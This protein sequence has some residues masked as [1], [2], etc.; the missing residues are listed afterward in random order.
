M[1]RI[2]A[3]DLETSG[4][5]FTSVYRVSSAEQTQHLGSLITPIFQKLGTEGRSWRVGISG[6]QGAGKSELARG[7]VHPELTLEA[8]NNTCRSI[9]SI[10]HVQDSGNILHYDARTLAALPFGRLSD[11][12][13][14]AFY[15]GLAEH[16]QM[17]PR[18]NIEITEWPEDD[19]AKM[20]D[21]LSKIERLPDMDEDS[22]LITVS[23]SQ[24]L[25]ETA[26]FADFI[27]EADI[28]AC[29]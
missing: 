17:K 6:E 3:K 25:S 22:R 16:H 12:S 9:R 15:R 26:A 7:I 23:C 2:N 24:E 20:I 11:D 10:L 13:S 27:S 29:E 18:A 5:L 14:I 19:S 8:I 21:L 1:E 28:Y 4:P